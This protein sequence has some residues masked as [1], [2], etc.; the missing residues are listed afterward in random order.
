M[1]D[2]NIIN[3]FMF[4]ILWRTDATPSTGPSVPHCGY[5]IRSGC[6]TRATNLMREDL[7]F[8]SYPVSI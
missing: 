6:S 8:F 5:D 2:F 4:H 3:G 7:S 1:D